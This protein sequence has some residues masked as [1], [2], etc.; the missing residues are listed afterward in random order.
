RRAPAGELQLA[1][2]AR[3]ARTTRP[4]PR[5]RQSERAATAHLPRA[6]APLDLRLAPGARAT[7]QRLATGR[8]ERRVPD[9]AATD[10]RRHPAR[11]RLL[12]GTPARRGLLHVV[13]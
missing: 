6:P 5:A 10:R 4:R 7:S 9:R 1:E 11:P 12:R 3:A 8:R 2:G 13:H